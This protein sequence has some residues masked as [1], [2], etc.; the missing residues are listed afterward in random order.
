MKIKCIKRLCNF[1]E[2]KIYEAHVDTCDLV[3]CRENGLPEDDAVIELFAHDD[4]TEE[5]G[6]LPITIATL[7]IKDY[8]QKNNLCWYNN[9]HF[10]EHFEI[11]E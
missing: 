11:V 7:S 2:G 10:K 6:D 5:D 8:Y 3:Y 1:N 4:F 9:K